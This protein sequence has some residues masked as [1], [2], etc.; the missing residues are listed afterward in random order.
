MKNYDAI[1]IGFGK[2]GKTL[3][4]FLGKKGKKVALI[5][6]N[7]N[8]YG[9]T[10]INV[11]CIPT[12]FLVEES[13]KKDRN[14]KEIIEHKNFFI[15]KLRETNFNKVNN[16][17]NVDIY[18]GIASFED[19][20]TI[21]ITNNNE[22]KFL[23]GELIFINTGATTVIPNIEGINETRNIYTSTSIMNLKELPKKLAIIGGGYI[24]LEFSSIFNN[25]GSE[26]TIFEEAEDI[27]LREEVE[28]V[29]EVKNNFKTRN[30]KV[31]NGTK[32]LKLKDCAQN[33]IEIT[34]EKNCEKQRKCFDAVLIAVGRKPNIK[35]LNLEKAKI[36]Y[37]DKGIEV[38][39]FLQTNIPHIYALG[40]VKGGLQFTYISLDDFR[41]IK[42]NLFDNQ[43]IST[44]SRKVIPYSVF[45][46]PTLSKVGIGEEQAKKLGYKVKTKVLK[47]MTIPRAKILQ[48]EK[49][50]LKSVIDEKTG[51]ILGCSLYSVESSEIINIVAMAI[52]EKKDYTYLRDFIFTHPTMAE[53]L[54]DLFDF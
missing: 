4:S 41:I 22:I 14:F 24:G 51:M 52:K 50:I 10:C 11:G 7:K 54:N 29:S 40:D 35:D 23:K 46:S 43:K 48:K 27:L 15:N 30:I 38:N 26:I 36:K 45:I 13:E 28:I 25:F 31:L 6:K 2:A 8:M 53:A 5:E 49:G 3:A 37:S 32:V 16:I 42:N 9:G 39:K 17:E 1:I 20:N 21:K 12:K 19:K 33:E 34:F 44:D 47:V 18:L